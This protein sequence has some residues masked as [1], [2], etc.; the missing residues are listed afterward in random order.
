MTG[1]RGEGRRGGDTVT[2]TLPQTIRRMVRCISVSEAARLLLFFFLF[3]HTWFCFLCLRFSLNIQRLNIQGVLI[4]FPN[5]C[6]SLK[7]Q[8][9]QQQLGIHMETPLVNKVLARGGATSRSRLTLLSFSIHLERVEML[10]VLSGLFFFFLFFSF[11]DRNE[12]N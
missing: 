9:Q 7:Q 10:F 4:F 3:F 8:Q 1:G 6:L 5:S 2:G 12:S 11:S